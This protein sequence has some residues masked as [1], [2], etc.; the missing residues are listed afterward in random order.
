MKILNLF[1]GIGGNRTLWGDKH[2]ITSIEINQQIACVYHK[3]FP[4]DKT[5]IGDAYDFFEKH[6]KEFDFIWA[7]PPCPTHSCMMSLQKNKKLPEMKLWSL[8]IFLKTWSKALWLVE[9]VKSYYKPLVN[10]TTFLG[11]HSI[12]S[13]IPLTNKRFDNKVRQEEKKINNARARG[14]MKLKDDLKWLSN[15]HKIDLDLLNGFSKG[16]KIRILRNCVDYRIGNHVLKSLNKQ[17]ILGDFLS[18]Q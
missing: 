18:N 9:N 3:R 12:W 8:I 10:P 7:S 15:K 1:A 17:T 16:K 2:E 4:K 14:F 6:Y 11:R 13:N 5:I